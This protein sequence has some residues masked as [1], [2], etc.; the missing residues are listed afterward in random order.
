LA[1]KQITRS[2]SIISSPSSPMDVATKTLYTPD[3]NFCKQYRRWDGET[4]ANKEQEFLF[5]TCRIVCWVF[6]V[7]PFNCL[8]VKEKGSELSNCHVGHNS[9]VK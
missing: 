6:W 7:C 3:R 2:T 1:S 8:P 5:D 4:N 9:T